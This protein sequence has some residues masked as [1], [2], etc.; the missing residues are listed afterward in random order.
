[1]HFGW[2]TTFGVIVFVSLVILF[3]MRASL[4]IDLRQGA[5]RQFSDQ[6]RIFGDRRIYIGMLPPMFNLAATYTFYTYLR[7]PLAGPPHFKTGAITLC[8]YFCMA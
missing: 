8:F 6:F 7:P 3:L 5:S 4:P 2:R 1:M